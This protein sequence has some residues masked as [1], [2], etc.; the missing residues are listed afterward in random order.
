M[1]D[2]MVP[3]SGV[4]VLFRWDLVCFEPVKTLGLHQIFTHIGKSRCRKKHH[5]PRNHTNDPTRSG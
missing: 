2:F 5:K 4:M 1:V 3:F